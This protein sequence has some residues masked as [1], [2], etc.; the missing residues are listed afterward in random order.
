MVY[1]FGVAVAL[2]LPLLYERFIEF[3]ISRPGRAENDASDRQ[4]RDD[5]KT[6]RAALR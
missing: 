4:A 3:V 1:V 5:S 6:A 2:A